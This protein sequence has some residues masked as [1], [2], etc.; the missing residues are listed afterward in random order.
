MLLPLTVALVVVQEMCARMGTVTGK[1]LADLI[2]EHF[3]LRL[4]FVIMMAVLVTNFGNAVSEFAGVAS[5]FELF[6]VSRY[7]SVPLGAMFV[8]WLVVFGTYKSV[9]KA[10]LIACLVYLAYPFSG[11][12]AQPNWTAA[13]EGSVVPRMPLDLASVSLVVGIIGTTIAPWMQFYLQSSVVEKESKVSDYGQV[14]LDVIIGSIM[15]VVVAFFIV[16]ACAATLHREGI[17]DIAL[18]RRGGA[19]AGAAGRPLRE[20]AVRDRPRQRLA[21]RC[22]DPAA[23]DGLLGVRGAGAGGRRRPLVRRGARVLLALHAARRSARPA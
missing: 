20:L 6:G 13:L 11:M 15:A 3:G 21:V 22:L 9:E 16:I 17:H 18:G 23:R 2:R 4:T 7:V 8:W 19:R 1:G 14:R 10:F 12:L 5:S